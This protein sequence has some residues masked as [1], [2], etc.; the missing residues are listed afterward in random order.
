[1]NK[2]LLMTSLLALVFGCIFFIFAL[3]IKASLIPLVINYIIA[4][5]LFISAYLAIHRN[6]NKIQLFTYLEYLTLFLIIFFT[7]VFLMQIF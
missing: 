5:L 3:S 6:N 4:I 7:I 2:K 1:M